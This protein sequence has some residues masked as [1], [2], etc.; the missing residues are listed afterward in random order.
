[1]V[2]LRLIF[3]NSD[4]DRKTW[5]SAHL[6]CVV[7]FGVF[8]YKASIPDI[9]LRWSTWRFMMVYWSWL[10]QAHRV[11]ENFGLGAI[12]R[13]I[14]LWLRDLLARRFCVT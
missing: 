4:L 14:S 2:G 3:K 1:M 8:W 5:Q 7:A 10:F 6:C 13:L 9:V 12:S 11:F